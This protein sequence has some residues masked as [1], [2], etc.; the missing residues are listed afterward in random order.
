[1]LNSSYDEAS[2]TWMQPVPSTAVDAN[3]PTGAG[4][5]PTSITGADVST[6]F[7]SG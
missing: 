5:K 4:T 3:V 7:A 6:P 1:V 2:L